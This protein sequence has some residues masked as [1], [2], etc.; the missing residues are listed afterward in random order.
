MK[1]TDYEERFLAFFKMKQ[2][3]IVKADAMQDKNEILSILDSWLQTKSVIFQRSHQQLGVAEANWMH[4]MSHISAIWI[5]HTNKNNN[6]GIFTNLKQDRCSW[7]R[8]SGFV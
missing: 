3:K 8:Y 6:T 4:Q 5:S 7:D 1:C 2:L